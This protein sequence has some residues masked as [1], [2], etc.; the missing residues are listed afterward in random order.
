MRCA[1]TPY[2]A[3]LFPFMSRDSAREAAALSDLITACCRITEYTLG[4]GRAEFDRDRK[5]RSACCYEI[6]IIG[7]AVKRLSM[8]TR[9]EHPEV[10]WKAIAGMRDHLI[11]GYDAVDIDELWKTATEDIPVLLEQVRKIQADLGQP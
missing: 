10:R 5:L 2:W 11:H 7:E 8:A 4:A 9:D 6:A 1:E 3:V